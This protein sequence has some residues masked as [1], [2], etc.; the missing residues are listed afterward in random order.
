MV[1]GHGSIFIVSG[2]SGSGKTSLCKELCNRMEEAVLSISTTTRT[3][4]EGE[5]EGEDYHFVERDAFL[6]KIEEDKFLEWAEVHGN[7][8][9]TEK[10]VVDEALAQ[11]KTVVFDI[12]VQGHASIR[13]IY[14]NQ[15][16]SVFVTTDGLKTLEARLSG[17]GTDS[18]EVIERRIINAL[19]E[20][21]RLEEYD[22]LLLNVEFDASLETMTAF[23][24]ASR[25]KRAIT[26]KEAFI[27]EWKT[28]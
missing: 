7:F 26:A 8:Y 9:G 28:H 24:K 20:M 14:P 27:G 1:E 12:D 13:E 21:R 25:F 18:K 11:G 17:R 2:P 6:K 4:R 15:T 22:Y 5:V 10:R 3:I 23:A 16:T 19:G